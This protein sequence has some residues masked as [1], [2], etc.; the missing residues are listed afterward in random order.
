M[1]RLMVSTSTPLAMSALTCVCRKAWKLTVGKLRARTKRC[2]LRE[3]VSG[4]MRAGVSCFNLYRA[5]AIEPGNAGAAEPWDQIAS[6]LGVDK[7]ELRR[8]YIDEIK[9][10]KAMA[11]TSAAEAGELTRAEKYAAHVILGAT[12]SHWQTELGNL[13]FDGLDSS[14]AKSAADAYAKW[15]LDGGRWNCSAFTTNF[16]DE[17]I[18]E[19]VALKIE[20]QKLL[21]NGG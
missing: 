5:P 1:R 15:L 14:G 10:G 11:A 13:I 18:A 7:N 6:R 17:R 19:F 16:S 4:A 3:K 2:Q 9:R 12:N 8:R 21:G 20:A